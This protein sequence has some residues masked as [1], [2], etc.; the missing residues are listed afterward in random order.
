M[1]GRLR[2]TRPALVPSHSHSR[3]T[4]AYRTGTRLWCRAWLSRSGGS[5]MTTD[6]VPSD[7]ASASDDRNALR[8]GARMPW[9]VTLVVLVGAAL[10]TAGAMIS[11]LAS[12]MLTNGNAMTGAARVYADYLF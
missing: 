3:G 2:A 7:D 9:W 6:A 8:L 12:T 11:K 4:G 1:I 10:L 5:A